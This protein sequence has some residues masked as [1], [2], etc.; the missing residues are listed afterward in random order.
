MESFEGEGYFGQR[1]L[2]ALALV[3]LGVALCLYTPDFSFSSSGAYIGQDPESFILTL[4]YA[5]AIMCSMALCYL[6]FYR[7]GRS[8]SSF[9]LATLLGIPVGILVMECIFIFLLMTIE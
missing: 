1:I 6:S 7:P 3:G 4:V 9:F 2:W 5:F 8:W